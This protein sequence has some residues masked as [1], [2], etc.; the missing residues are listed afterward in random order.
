MRRLGLEDEVMQAVLD[1]YLLTVEN[2]TERVDRLTSE[3]EVKILA[4]SL[5]PLVRGLMVLRGV[6]VVTAST[7]AAE[8][9][10]FHR[11]STAKQFMAYVGLTPTEDSSGERV[12][13]G[14]ITQGSNRHVRRLLVEAA[15]HY[16][17]R[18]GISISSS[19]PVMLSMGIGE[20]SCLGASSFVFLSFSALN[21]RSH[22]RRVSGCRFFVCPAK[23]A[24]PVAA[25]QRPCPVHG[26]MNPIRKGVAGQ[27]RGLK[28]AIGGCWNVA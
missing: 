12:R 9:G 8:I 26:E 1:D 15:Q 27:R 6:A 28:E 24:N 13:R 19:R 22:W 20:I 3:L 21:S 11:F 16:R 4:S 7:F 2:A 23:L 10:D 14:A 25:C 17:R 18:P 5:A